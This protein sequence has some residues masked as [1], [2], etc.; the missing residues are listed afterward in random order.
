MSERRDATAY[1]PWFDD[2][3]RFFDVLPRNAVNE[4]RQPHDCREVVL[5]EVE[6]Q[7][8]LKKDR[9]RN[10]TY[11]ERNDYDPVLSTFTRQGLLHLIARPS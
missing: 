2:A 6:V 11:D 7:L 1:R 9:N 4:R 8:V 10:F 3:N 5:A